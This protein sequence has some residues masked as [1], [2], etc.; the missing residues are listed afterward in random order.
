[1]HYPTKTDELLEKFQNGVSSFWQ[2]K[3]SLMV[4]TTAVVAQESGL[5]LSSFEFSKL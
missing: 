3:A 2:G 5:N 4:I 1:M